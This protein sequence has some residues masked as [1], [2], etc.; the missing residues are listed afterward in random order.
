M[1]M[2]YAHIR[3]LVLPIF[4]DMASGYVNTLPFLTEE[5]VPDASF[6]YAKLEK[7]SVDQL[8]RWLACRGIKISGNKTALLEM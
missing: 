2:H 3:A 5:D 8:R 1:D 7:H 4:T 6:I